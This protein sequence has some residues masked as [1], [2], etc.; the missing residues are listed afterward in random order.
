MSRATKR[1]TQLLTTLASQLQTIRNTRVSTAKL[2]VVLL[3][4]V[5][6]FG[7][8]GQAARVTHGYARN[9]LVPNQ[10]AQVQ[11]RVRHRQRGGGMHAA[12]AAGEAEA[13]PSASALGAATP[14]QAAGPPGEADEWS[15]QQQEAGAAIRR[16][17][18][19][20]LMVKRKTTD[21]QSLERP[22]A[23][24]DLAE[25]VARQ[26]RVQL[27]P[28]HIDLGGE[29]LGVVGEYLIPLKLLLPNGERVVLDVNVAST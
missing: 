20:P 18:T 7:T 5:E 29:T 11:P 16:L 22:L 21:G 8:A 2:P 4:D 19:S 9:F 10:L 26:L 23:A 27:V 12:T 24:A 17:S 14:A 6:G 3:Q 25:V 13:G 28:E 15:S 1:A